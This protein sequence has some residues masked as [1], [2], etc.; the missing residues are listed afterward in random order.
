MI[1]S[2][3]RSSPRGISPIKSRQ[4]HM[5]S[6]YLILLPRDRNRTRRGS[7]TRVRDLHECACRSPKQHWSDRSTRPIGARTRIH[8]VHLGFLCGGW[9]GEFGSDFGLGEKKAEVAELGSK[10]STSPVS[11]CGR[12]PMP[13]H[14]PVSPYGLRNER[15]ARTAFE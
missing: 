12:L 15:R 10:G 8:T 4:S 9:R 3:L 14:I 5:Y 13:R 7:K 2:P 6:I 11:A 1:Y